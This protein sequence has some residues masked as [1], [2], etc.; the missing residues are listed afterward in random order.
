MPL[1]LDD[2]I[3]FTLYATSIAVTR[4]Y[5]PLLDAMC[6]TYPQYL[7][8]SVLGEQDGA[9]V[10]AIAN[11][12]VLASSTVTPLVKRLEQVGLVRRARSATDERQVQVWLTQPGHECLARSAC[13]GTLLV[14]R[15]GMTLEAVAALNAQVKTLQAALADKP[16]SGVRLSSRRE[17]SRL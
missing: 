10:G 6:I 3:C 16:K 4:T 8:L 2:Q 9:T 13:L 17:A 5:K 11:R 15:S 1:L 7:V 12:L 14:E